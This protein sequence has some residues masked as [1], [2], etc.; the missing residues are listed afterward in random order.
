MYF[1]I[2]KDVFFHTYKENHG[3]QNDKFIFLKLGNKNTPFLLLPLTISK[4]ISISLYF[5]KYSFGFAVHASELVWHKI[6]FSNVNWN[7]F[8]LYFISILFVPFL[9]M[10]LYTED[11]F[12][13]NERCFK[14]V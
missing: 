14:P 5:Y 4:R 6:L 10:Q 12:L 8:F 11:C 9:S 7:Q 13:V 1:F 3:T 2:F